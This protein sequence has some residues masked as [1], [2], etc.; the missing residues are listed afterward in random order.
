M[1][2][3]MQRTRYLIGR[4]FV[5]A[6]DFCLCHGLV[7][8]G[9]SLPFGVRFHHDL[10]RVL[11]REPRTVVDAGGNVG[12]T[13]LAFSR[14][15]PRARIVSIEPVRATYLELEQRCRGNGRIQCLNLALGAENGLAR[16][17][18]SANSELSS[19]IT[20]EEDD[21]GIVEE[22]AM[23]RLDG[24]AR[25]LGVDG[26]DLLKI[27]TEGFELQVLKGAEELVAAGGV[28]AVYAECR[29]SRNKV[30]QVLFQ[31]LDAY[32]VGCGYIFSG[33]YEIYRWG[34]GRRYAAFANGLWIRQ[35]LP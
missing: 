19:V 30:K 18:V 24:L 27:D 23:R 6:L 31:D 29:F 2:Q 8:F 17:R 21:P 26:I 35:D 10:K 15:W 3:S 14:Y 4:S 9:S 22:V 12:Q 20:G 33:F 34:P 7:P 28:S 1:R 13:A 32:L 25:E 11:G 5:G 16:M